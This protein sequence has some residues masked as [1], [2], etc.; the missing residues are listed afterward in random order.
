VKVGKLFGVWGKPVW[1]CPIVTKLE[2]S[3]EPGFNGGSQLREGPKKP[4]G[5]LTAIL[6]PPPPDRIDANLSLFQ[7]IPK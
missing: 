1:K 3:S 6:F 7:G 5:H 4:R 2:M